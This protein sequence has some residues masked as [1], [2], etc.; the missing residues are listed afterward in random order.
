MD[1]LE[2]E[3]TLASGRAVIGPAA[4]AHL[5]TCEACRSLVE[6][7]GTLAASLRGAAPAVGPVPSAELDAL[8]ARER[9]VRA[10]LRGLARL[11]RVGLAG[12]FL[13][14]LAVLILL[15]RPRVDLDTFPRARLLLAVAGF[16]ALALLG[17]WHSLRPIYLPPAPAWVTWAVFALGL[18]GPVAWALLPEVPTAHLPIDGL[19]PVRMAH[20]FL[21]GLVSGAAL[22][23]IVRGLDRGGR[24]GTDLA[25]LGAAFGGLTGNVGLLLNCPNNYP[26][27]LLLGHATI[28]LGLIVVV[29]I[30]TRASRRR[31]ASPARR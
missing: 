2:L 11:H 26:L 6:D 18:A 24:S 22:L 30:A 8:L 17:V 9:G 7:N 31:Q 23:A 13:A 29:A 4:E 27:H 25:L 5:R 19:A 1:C 15:G 3:D 20:C 10:R 12:A 28:P 14:A 21:L 16:A